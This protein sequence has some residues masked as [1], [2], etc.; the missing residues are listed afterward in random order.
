MTY[1]DFLEPLRETIVKTKS[2]RLLGREETVIRQTAADMLA[3]LEAL[4]WADSEMLPGEI[5]SC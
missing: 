3:N 5:T 4:G 1:R 2:D